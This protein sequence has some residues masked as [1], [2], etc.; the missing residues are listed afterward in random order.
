MRVDARET[1]TPVLALNRV[2]RRSA[3]IKERNLSVLFSLATAITSRSGGVCAREGVRVS[4][5]DTNT[6][7]VDT[8]SNG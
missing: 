5:E 1:N 2:H 6:A 7:T 4:E 3:P 8:F